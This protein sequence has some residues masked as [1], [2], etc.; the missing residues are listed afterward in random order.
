MV[1]WK[2]NQLNPAGAKGHCE[3][4]IGHFVVECST[5]RLVLKQY[6]ICGQFTRINNI[7]S[8]GQLCLQNQ[9]VSKIIF[10]LNSTN[11]LVRVEHLSRVSRGLDSVSWLLVLVFLVFWSQLSV[12]DRVHYFLWQCKFV[13]FCVQL[14]IKKH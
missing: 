1:A 2:D 9:K 3:R 10:L 11:S 8:R 13:S 5:R 7:M 12:K 14:S 6:I 4:N